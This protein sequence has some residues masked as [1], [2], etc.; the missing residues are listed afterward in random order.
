MKIRRRGIHR[1][2]FELLS[3]LLRID[4]NYKVT[5]VFR[6]DM[7][8]MNDSF[9]IIIEGPEAPLHIE[10]EELHSMYELPK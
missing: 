1:I 2:S 9:S 6:R 4:E 7:D 3:E 10:G 8:K 5:D